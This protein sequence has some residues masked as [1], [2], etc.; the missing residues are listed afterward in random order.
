MAVRPIKELT[1]FKVTFLMN[2]DLHFHNEKDDLTASEV[3]G[4][5][6]R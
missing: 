6:L 2:P 1:Y 5:F 3:F 4:A